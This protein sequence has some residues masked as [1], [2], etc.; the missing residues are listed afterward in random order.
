MTRRRWLLA[1]FA[2]VS[3]LT[4]RIVAQQPTSPS[5]QST[6]SAPA[7][8][9]P[10]LLRVQ[11]VISRRQGDKTI[12][13]QPYMLTV[14]ADGP[15]ASLKMGVQVAVPLTVDGGKTPYSYKD[16]GTSID[17]SAHTLE[18]GRFRLE[19]GLVDN[20][21]LSDDPSSASKGMPQFG[22]FSLGNEMAVLKDG[23]TTTLTTAS[24]KAT[25]EVITVDVTLNVIK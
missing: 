25:G 16:M 2:V 21:V 15:R 22:S 14:T 5:A 23:Q 13:R 17:C 12:S 20:F 18:G 10:T 9:A 3:M 4:G 19:M 11:V 1:L 8:P 7:V 6:A 24:Q